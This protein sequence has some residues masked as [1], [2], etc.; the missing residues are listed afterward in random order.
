MAAQIDIQSGKRSPRGEIPKWIWHQEREKRQAIELIRE[1]SLDQAVDGVELRVAL[2]GGVEV[3]LDGSS[4]GRLEESAANVCSFRRI[5][6][7]PTRL[8]AGNHKLRLSVRCEA[9]MPIVPINIHLHERSVGCIGYLSGESFWLATDDEWSAGGEQSA[10]VVCLLGEEPFGDLEDGP[11]WFVAG[12]FG[13]IEVRPLVG[14]SVLEASGLNVSAT[15][16]SALLRGSGQGFVTLPEPSRRDLHIFYHVRKQTEWRERNEALRD[17]NAAALPFCTLDL[18]REYNVRFRLRNVSASSVA[19]IWNGAESLPELANYEGLITEVVRLEAG[20]TPF[21]LPQGLRYFRLYVMAEDGIPFELEWQA[22]EVGVP[23]REAG[24]LRTDSKLLK[25]IYDIS[26]HTNRICHQI[27]LWDGIKRDRLNWTY[28]FYL[29]AKA[30]YALWDDLSVLKRSI[31]ELGRGTPGGYWMNAIPAY[32]LWWLNNIWE[33]YL[34]TGDKEFVLSLEEEIAR[35]CDQVSRNIDPTTNELINVTPTLIEW[36]PMGEEEGR[37]GMQ[38]L[39]RLTGDRLRR[40]GGYIPELNGLPDWSYPEI[41]P[42]RFLEGEQLITRLLGIL[43]GYVGNEQGE[44]FLRSYE[45]RDPITPLSAYWLADCCSMLGLQEKA[46]EA[47]SQVWGKMLAEG[48]TTCWES[49]KLK[50]DGDFHDALTT[51]TAYDSYRISLCHSWAGTPVHWIVARVLGVEPLEP[52]YSSIAFNPRL[53]SGIESCVGT[54]PTPFGAITAGWDRGN[55]E[56]LVLRLPDGIA[57][58]GIEAR[59]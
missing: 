58:K 36:V 49:V 38:A 5:E 18:G 23:I 50:H 53:I 56:T 25:D 3:E 29:A 45:V 14:F 59:H 11:E 40:L 16:M 41:E 37:L 15:S 17:S 42:E 31:E 39:L 7:F 43:S 32:T 8:E 2:T 13:D 21:T 57:A 54:I 12:G 10:A 24:T 27:G 22:E 33:Y 52:G 9:F 46:W 28:D 35:H 6:G 48:A 51:Y 34:H 44:A 55:E 26:V 47:I 19:L 30:D 1:F 4:V 20:E